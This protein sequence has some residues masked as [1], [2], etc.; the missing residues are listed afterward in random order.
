[1]SDTN[2]FLS[3]FLTEQPQWIHEVRYVQRPES[4]EPEATLSTNAMWALIRWS[5]KNGFV[6]RLEHIPDL[7]HVLTKAERNDCWT[8]HADDATLARRAAKCTC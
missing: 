1:M 8:T 3:L 5:L 2:D 4:D 7:L 6:R